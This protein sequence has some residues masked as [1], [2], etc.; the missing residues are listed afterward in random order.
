MAA[1]YG[2]ADARRCV[3]V[4]CASETDICAYVEMS[5]AVRTDVIPRAEQPVIGGTNLGEPLRGTHRCWFYVLDNLI[6]FVTGPG[7]RY[8]ILST[9]TAAS[10]GYVTLVTAPKGELWLIPAGAS[11][12]NPT[13]RTPAI[14]VDGLWALPGGLRNAPATTE[15]SATLIAPTA[16]ARGGTGDIGGGRG[17]VGDGDNSVDGNSGGIGGESKDAEEA[18]RRVMPKTQKHI[19]AMWFRGL[20]GNPSTRTTHAAARKMRG[21]VV[22]TIDGDTARHCDRVN[23]IANGRSTTRTPRSRSPSTPL[24]P[25]NR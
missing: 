7:S 21:Q 16:C 18:G 24:V 17:A 8:N 23:R 14:S 4:D 2:E 3:Y 6:P 9:G 20:L 1:G 10:L 5:R 13:A 22:V 15:R 12:D 19:S 11:L 25:S